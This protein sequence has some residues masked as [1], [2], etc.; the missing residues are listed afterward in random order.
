MDNFNFGVKLWQG[1]LYLSD[2]VFDQNGKI[3]DKNIIWIKDLVINVNDK[4]VLKYI[5]KE[6]NGLKYMFFEWK[7]GDYIERGENFWYYVLK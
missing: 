4:I 5:I 2:L 1:D 7:N 3:E 6:I